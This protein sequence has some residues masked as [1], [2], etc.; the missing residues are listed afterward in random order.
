MGRE[1]RKRE[2]RGAFIA[3]TRTQVARDQQ[4]TPGCDC[5]RVFGRRGR[6]RMHG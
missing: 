1:H 3:A 2:P 4:K 6:G 5:S